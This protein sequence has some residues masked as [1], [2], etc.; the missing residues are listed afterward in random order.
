[1]RYTF[2]LRSSIAWH[3]AK[4]S[5]ATGDWSMRSSFVGAI[6]FPVVEFIC[7]MRP[8]NLLD[9]I[10]P[11]EIYL[12]VDVFLCLTSV[13]LNWNC[14]N[15]NSENLSLGPRLLNNKTKGEEQGHFDFWHFRNF[16]PYHSF[17][18]HNGHWPWRVKDVSVGVLVDP[19]TGWSA[20]GLMEPDGSSTD[21]SIGRRRL[22]SPPHVPHVLHSL[23]FVLH[24]N[25]W[26]KHHH[27]WLCPHVHSFVGSSCA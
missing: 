27:M 10:Y 14:N 18:D 25:L 4:G 12:Q 16:Q 20:G 17:C 21:S 1:M 19:I 6:L 5:V 24:K 26:W 23:G 22:Q 7:L 13:W 9:R 2:E 15:V 8:I 3:H 11:D